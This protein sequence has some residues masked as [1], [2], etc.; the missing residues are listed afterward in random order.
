MLVNHA[1]VEII[2]Q[3]AM[4]PTPIGKYGQIKLP[5][6]RRFFPL[7]EGQDV[8][9][10]AVGQNPIPVFSFRVSTDFRPAT[11]RS[12]KRSSDDRDALRLSEFDCWN[13]GPISD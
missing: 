1:L 2:Q 8:V 11:T 10:I 5:L 4:N 12:F 3:A 9:V 6:K 7:D 13:T